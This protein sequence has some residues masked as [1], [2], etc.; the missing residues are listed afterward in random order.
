M[1][2]KMSE[3]LQGIGRA[4]AVKNSSSKFRSKCVVHLR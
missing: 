2:Y 4:V 1:K 3:K